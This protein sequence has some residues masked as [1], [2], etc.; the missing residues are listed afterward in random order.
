MCGDKFNTGD[1]RSRCDEIYG[2]ELGAP[3]SSL[4]SSQQTFNDINAAEVWKFE[5]SKTGGQGQ[6]VEVINRIP[7]YARTR[8][9][10]VV[11]STNLSYKTRLQ[12]NMTTM[13]CYMLLSSALQ[14]VPVIF[15][16][17][18]LDNCQ[19]IGVAFAFACESLRIA[20]LRLFV[21]F[22]IMH[23]IVD[24]LLHHAC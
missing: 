1:G 12:L 22:T 16:V 24:I 3:L 15:W 20:C 5:N 14:F 11:K 21:C 19:V 7:S 8:S 18:Y 10:V 2:A 23:C 13:L 4:S 6:E 17:T 9:F